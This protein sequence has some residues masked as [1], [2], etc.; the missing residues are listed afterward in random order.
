MK[1]NFYSTGESSENGLTR[2]EMDA[3]IATLDCMCKSL[4]ADVVLLRERSVENL[5]VSEF[6]V[7]KR[8]DLKDFVEV[9]WV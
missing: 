1:T 9:R 5:F 4:D 6:L 2:D 8:A 7:R 3:S